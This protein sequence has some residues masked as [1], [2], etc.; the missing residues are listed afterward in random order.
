VDRI[1]AYL[2]NYTVPRLPDSRSLLG[3]FRMALPLG[4]LDFGVVQFDANTLADA[5]T[6]FI[7]AG[8][9]GAKISVGDL[10]IVKRAEDNVSMFTSINQALQAGTKLFDALA[11][12]SLPVNQRPEITVEPLDD[13]RGDPTYIDIGRAVYYCFMTILLRGKAPEYEAAGNTQPVPRFLTSVMAL[14]RPPSW[15]VQL[16][17]SFDL[18]L[19]DHTWIKHI[20][21]TGLD[22]K[23]QNRLALGM[24]GYRLPGALTMYQFRADAPAHAVTAA[25]A[26][27]QFV[28]RGATWD[29]HAVTRSAAFLDVVKNFNANCGNIIRAVYTAEQ[30]QTLVTLRILYAAPEDNPRFTQWESW[31]DATFAGFTDMIF[32]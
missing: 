1:L 15:Y 8:D 31:T 29:C 2:F 22:A 19:F 14:T 24:A 23:T 25:N 5:L 12:F 9:G 3:N 16:I 17:S 20:T 32:A 26:V 10:R 13:Q 7:Q 18:N 28:Q 21:I 4:V 27:K 11:Y 30:I 6:P